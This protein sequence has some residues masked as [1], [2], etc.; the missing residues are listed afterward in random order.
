[1]PRENNR[2]YELETSEHN[3]SKEISDNPPMQKNNL[4]ELLQE[5]DIN[6]ANLKITMNTNNLV[7]LINSGF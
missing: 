4:H 6:N 5:I 2:I 3:D 7:N 1:M